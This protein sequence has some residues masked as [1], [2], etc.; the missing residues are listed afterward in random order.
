VSQ[1]E[2]LTG[3]WAGLYSYPWGSKKP[4][5]FTATLADSNEW[6]TG[7]TEEIA[8]VGSSTGK[9]ITATLQGRRT[10]RSVTFLKTYD[11]VPEGYDAVRYE[12]DVN[13]DGTEIEGRWTIPG[14]WSGRFLMTRAGQIGIALVQKIEEKV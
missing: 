2:N 14:N 7:Y 4:V 13:E 11:T 3:P 6:I 10:G 8:T 1:S 12:G 5:H 9:T